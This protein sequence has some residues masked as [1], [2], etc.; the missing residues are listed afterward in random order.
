M[1][2][3]ELSVALP[4]LYY[5]AMDP[6]EGQNCLFPCPVKFDNRS[7]T[8]PDSIV[9][10]L[11]EGTS[12]LGRDASALDNGSGPAARPQPRAGGA[13]RCFLI[14][15]CVLCAVWVI[16]YA[17]P[18]CQK[19]QFFVCFNLCLFFKTKIN[20]LD[21]VSSLCFLFCQQDEGQETHKPSLI[22]LVN[23][24]VLHCFCFSLFSWLCFSLT[25]ADL[26]MV[27][28]L[29]YCVNKFL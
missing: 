10:L 26:E 21:L 14:Y 15:I 16:K 24:C 11:S 3:P 6:W 29:K 18:V 9:L 1:T 4:H 22:L 13:V 2:G 27:K 8:S 23:N 28:S 25:E 17:I 19:L 7:V 12:G 5:M 20:F